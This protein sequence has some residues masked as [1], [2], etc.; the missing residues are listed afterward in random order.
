MNTWPEAFGGTCFPAQAAQETRRLQS[1]RR[2]GGRH[3]YASSQCAGLDSGVDGIIHF[4]TAQRNRATQIY[5][6]LGR[7]FLQLLEHGED[8]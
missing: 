7:K 1:G 4:Y 6:N 8:K 2:S 3:Q 5:R